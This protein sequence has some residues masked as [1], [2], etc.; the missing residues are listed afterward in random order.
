MALTGRASIRLFETDVDKSA[1]WFALGTL[2]LRH[3]N[4]A[5]SV[6]A[7]QVCLY[8]CVLYVCVCMFV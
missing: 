8:V 7:Y 2:L 3:G 5:D 6:T 1:A 4:L